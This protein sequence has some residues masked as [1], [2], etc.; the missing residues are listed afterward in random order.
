MI[1]TVKMFDYW[2]FH[3]AGNVQFFQICEGEIVDYREYASVKESP[4][5]LLR[6]DM[7]YHGRTYIAPAQPEHAPGDKK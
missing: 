2:A 1:E 4:V 5:F 7:R 3:D 6:D